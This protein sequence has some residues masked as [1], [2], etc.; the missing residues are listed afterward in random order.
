MGGVTAAAAVPDADLRSCAEEMLFLLHAHGVEYL[1]LNPGTDS[2]PLQEAVAALASRGV[3]GPQLVTCS[4]ESAALAAA[5]GYWQVTR[6]PQAV[7]VHVDVGTQNL[8]AMVHNV[9]RDHAGVVVLAGKTPYGEDAAALGGRSHPIHWLQDVPDQAG[10]VR[11]YAKWTAELTRSRDTARLIGRA[12]QVAGGG[13][14]G[15]AY[16]T[17][18]RDVLMEPAGPRELRRIGRFARPLP[19]SAKPEAVT[20]L[21]EMLVSARRP[22]I[23]TSRLGR[24]LEGARALPRL[25][26]MAAI[27]VAGRPEAV[28]IPSDHP[29]GARSAGATAAL[30]RTA[31]LVVVIDCDVPWVPGSVAPADGAL[32]VQIDA[33]PVKADMP[34][35]TFPVDMAITADGAAAIVQLTDAIAAIGGVPGPLA[36]ERRQWLASVTGRDDRSTRSDLAL[37]RGPAPGPQVHDVVAVLNQLLQPHDIVLEEAVSNDWLVGELLARS[38]PGTLYTAGGSGLGWSLGASIGVKLARPDRRVVAL[39]GDGAFMFAVPTAALC[40]AAEAQAPFTAVVL[41]NDGYRASRQPVE[42]LFPNGAWAARG[43]VA[44]TRFTRPPAFAALATACGAHGERV[45]DAGRLPA[46]IEAALR[47]TDQGQAAVVDVALA[48]Q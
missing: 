39:V 11:S 36:D 43:E 2:A 41:N 45:T 26:G 24:T 37:H 6:R 38:E 48:G 9:L 21:A 10:I 16:L 25:A 28:N 47:V 7:F 19:P 40:L 3:P 8:G 44:G 33:D 18:S 15:L 29:M 27:P 35:W 4:F 46:A 20:E 12:V 31:D 42:A 22:V 30:V 5:H 1:F 17:V 14:P 23:V 34:L 13:Q 32:V